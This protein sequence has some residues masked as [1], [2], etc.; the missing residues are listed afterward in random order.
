VS[1]EHPAT[2][3]LRSVPLQD[4]L[5]RCEGDDALL[6][7]RA[8]L[9]ESAADDVLACGPEAQA[10]VTEL[11]AF[12]SARDGHH[13]QGDGP[14]LM[15]Q[16][17]RAYAEDIVVLTP[18]EPAHIVSA[19]ALCF[20]NR[21]RLADKVGRP[22]LA[23]HAPVPDYAGRLSEQVDF[24]LARLRPQRCFTRSNWGLTS[25]PELHLPHAVAPV[26]LAR[27]A[28]FF[29]RE[30]HQSF[31]KL[32]DSQAVVFTIR[33]VVTAWADMTPDVRA[34]IRTQ[35]DAL[36]AEWRAYKSIAGS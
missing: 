13:F 2:I 11:A 1:I 8:E 7:R 33:T 34:A 26:N 31:V 25:T 12:L 28:V 6:R 5:A 15:A 14:Q 19:A 3:G 22:L 21:W 16:L 32:E 23:V 10:A 29:V 18:R 27:D 4:W 17:G 24:F 20:P 35:T 9:I 30:E 36:S